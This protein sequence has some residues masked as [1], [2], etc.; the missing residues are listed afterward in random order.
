MRLL[1]A[2]FRWGIGWQV[3]LWLTIGVAGGLWFGE[4]ALVVEPIGE[5]FLRLLMMAA[6]PLV[7]FNLLAGLTALD[8]I[9]SF[10]RI[11]WRVFLYYTGTTTCAL[12]IGIVLMLA[13]Q[14]GAGAPV[15]GE[16]PENLGETPS[17]W[18]TIIGLVPRN[19]FAALAE[20]KVASIVVFTALFG[21]ATLSLPV[22]QR[23]PLGQF[24]DRVAQA[25]RRLVGGILYLAPYGVAALAATTIGR[26]G[27]E[28]LGPM[29]KLIGAIWIGQLA[30]VA[31]YL[32]L[33]KLL[34]KASP[35]RFLQ[36]SAPL[37]ATTATTCSSL[38]SLAVSLDI[39]GRK[40][41]L[42][43]RIYGFTLPLG[44]Q[45]NKDGT[46]IMLTGVLLFTAQAAG[47]EFGLASLLAVLLIGLLLS[48]GSGGLPGGGF[49]VSLIFVEAFNLPLEIAAAVA[50][51]YRLID[52]GNTTINCMGDL[53]GTSIVSKFEERRSASKSV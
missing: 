29:A 9:G 51:V 37:Y 39:A 21:V 26:H 25:L 10:G 2:Y 13:I 50:G 22:E 24:F 5:L 53:V 35:W 19:V 18:G 1:K 27:A 7:V 44:A 47:V 28:L 12:T 40:L 49:V 3:L 4:G 17:V 45:I 41:R 48:E 30:M 46:S 52:M 34:V 32:V 6:I 11:G 15:V 23:Q 14:P 38:A 8:D 36:L 20:G 16:V 33:Y 42:P 31:L 43:K